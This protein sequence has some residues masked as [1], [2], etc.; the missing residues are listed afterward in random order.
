M[1]IGRSRRNDREKTKKLRAATAPILSP[2]IFLE[3]REQ[4]FCRIDGPRFAGRRASTQLTVQT[5]ERE[6]SVCA[7]NSAPAHG[8]A[9]R[10]P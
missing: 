7:R 2:H 4:V 6:R 9:I 8:V 1:T 5:A 10:C 3:K